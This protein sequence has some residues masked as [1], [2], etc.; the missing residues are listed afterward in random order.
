VILAISDVRPNEILQQLASRGFVLSSSSS[1][2]LYHQLYLVLQRAIRDHALEEGA[3]FPSEE[4]VAAHFAVSRPT[5]SRAIRELVG[6]GWLTRR[7]GRGTFVRWAGPTQL[8]LLNNSLSFSDG[9]SHRED[10]R[11]QFI[12]RETLVASQ[13]DAV[14]LQLEMGA[15]IHY[16]RRLHTVADRVVMVCD[17]KLSA[18]RFPGLLDRE[19]VDD[20]LFKTLAQ[21]YGCTVRRAERCVE[22]AEVLTEEI[23]ALLGSPMFA[24]ILMMTGLAFD[25]D[26]YPVEAMT[27][28]VREG[29]MFKNVITP[30]SAETA[31]RR[32]AC[33][34]THTPTGKAC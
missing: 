22:A 24:P 30:R 7:R 13:E 21:H 28:Y 26:P 32:E 10:H 25:D 12:R 17:S 16:I 8:S 34:R 19:F 9:I 29:V 4:A 15:Q 11:T 20:S 14:A 3:Q 2:P 1:L 5:A 27:A 23:A 6:Q 18:A 31:P 33:P